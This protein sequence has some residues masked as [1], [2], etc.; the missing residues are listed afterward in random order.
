MTAE[1][2]LLTKQNGEKIQHIKEDVKTIVLGLSNIQESLDELVGVP[3]KLDGL[4][5]TT[6]AIMKDL[7][8][9]REQHATAS[10][11]LTDALI[12]LGNRVVLGLFLLVLACMAGYF[13]MKI[14]LNQGGVNFTQEKLQ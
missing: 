8:V 9:T 13:S 11:R 12:K 3:L 4:D 10:N 14:N 5:L 2:T 6:K 1:L 7:A